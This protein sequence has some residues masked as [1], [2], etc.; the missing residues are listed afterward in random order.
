[1]R[2]AVI[3]LLMLLSLVTKGQV[4]T[5]EGK[6]VGEY[7]FEPLSGVTIQTVDKVQ[8]GITDING[9][10]KVELPV[11][12]DQLLLQA[13]KMESALVTLKADCSKL[14]IIMLADG[15]HDF[16]T[17]SRENNERYKRF[18][19]LSKK[20]KLAYTKAAFTS[21]RPCVIYTFQEH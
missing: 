21:D 10:F 11:A 15:P 19:A 5:I 7:D 8:L 1:M 13:L 3:A 12:A 6:V 17:L 20:H 14:E 16:M 2:S 9:R 18:K 4:R